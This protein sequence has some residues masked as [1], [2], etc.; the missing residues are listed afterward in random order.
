MLAVQT[1]VSS[2]LTDAPLPIGLAR[3][4]SEA[5][6]TPVLLIA[7]QPELRGDRYL[8]DHAPGNVQLWELPGTP[9]TRGLAQHP[10][11]WEQRVIAFL[12]RTLAPTR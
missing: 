3:A 7:G 2:V 5:A 1:A 8:R 9:H 6:P 10:A 12:D 4:L 11:A